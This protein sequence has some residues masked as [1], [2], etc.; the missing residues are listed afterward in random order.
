MWENGYLWNPRA[1]TCK[2]G[3]YLGSIIDAMI[4]TCDEIT[5]VTK[6]VPT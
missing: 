1:C 3:K 6:I 5:E 2:N 4:V